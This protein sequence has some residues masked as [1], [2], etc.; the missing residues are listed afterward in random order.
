M[1][2]QKQNPSLIRNGGVRERMPR[3][4]RRDLLDGT[5]V[6]IFRAAIRS[7][8]TLDPYERKLAYFLE[9]S[10]KSADKLIEECKDSKTAEQ[11][12]IKFILE[13]KQRV[14]RKEITGGTMANTINA[15]RLFLEMNDVT[16]NWR[17]IRRLMP[18]VKRFADDRVPTRE[19]LRLILE[20]A[21]IRGRALTLTFISSGIREGSIPRLKVS[22]LAPIE[23]DGQVICGRLV[24]YAGEPEQ[25]VAFISPEAYGALQA[26]IEYR[27]GRGEKIGDDSPLFRDRFDADAYP[28]IQIKKPKPDRPKPLHEHGIRNYYNRLFHII[29]MRHGKKRRHPVSVHGF[30][31]YYKTVAESA[32]MK[33]IEVETLLAH[34]TGIS[35][36]YYR[37]TETDL[38]SA[39]LKIVKSLQVTAAAEFETKLEEEKTVNAH[40]IADL[41]QKLN[42]V[43]SSVLSR[44][45]EPSK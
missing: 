4:F 14:A 16:L 27:K 11:T 26:Y 12:V 6:E 2:V 37:P 20:A 29:G 34:S 43:L 40:K 30:R 33:P 13:E 8:Q 9:W 44:P 1:F 36:S 3:K 41:E 18:P 10:G 5:S 21:D 45:P 7:P 42:S 15:V 19:E 38:A 31:K 28:Y 24:V 25:Y 22:H 35:D 32:G 17:K 39:Y 23:H